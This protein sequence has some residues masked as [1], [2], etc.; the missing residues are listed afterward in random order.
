MMCAMA[1]RAELWKA[2]LRDLGA[3]NGNEVRGPG[4]KTLYIE[5]RG[6]GD[7]MAYNGRPERIVLNGPFIEEHSAKGVKSHLIEDILSLNAQQN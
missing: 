3:L 2:K 4:T 5:F 6:K 7:F 1:D